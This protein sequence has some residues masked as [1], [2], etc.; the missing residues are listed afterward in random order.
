MSAPTTALRGRD[1]PTGGRAQRAEDPPARDAPA[2]L[3]HPRRGHRDVGDRHPH[4]LLVVG[5]DRVHPRRRRLRGRRAA[6]R[7]GRR[8]PARDAGDDEHRLSAAAAHLDPDVRDRDRPVDARVRAEPWPGRRRLGTLAEDRA[9]AGRPPGRVRQ[10]RPGDLSRPLAGQAGVRDPRPAE[11]HDPV[12]HH[13][14]ADRRARPQGARSRDLDGP[15]RHRDD[16]VRPGRREPRPLRRARGQRPDRDRDVRAAR[17]S[18]RA[19]PGLD[20]PVGGPARASATTRS[21]GCW[22]SARVGSSGS[23]WARVAAP[24]DCSCR[25]PATTSSSRSSAR[26]SGWSAP[27]SSSPCS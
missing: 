6:G 27:G 18:A 16:D 19:D 26:S 11:R 10:A 24:A 8:R 25:M 12:P 1:P 17:L 13:L 14:P 5:D 23:A 4:G 15:G 2:G 7:L 3:H 22:R 20:R 21:R 9:V